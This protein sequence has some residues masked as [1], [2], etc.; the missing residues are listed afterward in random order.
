M[1]FYSN[2]IQISAPTAESRF[3]NEVMSIHVLLMDRK[4]FNNDGHLGQTSI[5]KIHRRINALH[6]GYFFMLFVI[7]RFFMNSFFFEKFF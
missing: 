3:V 7:C 5:R 2:W 6:V 4:D 1:D